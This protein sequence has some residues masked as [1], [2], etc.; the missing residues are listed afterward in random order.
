MKKILFYSALLLQCRVGIS[1]IPSLYPLSLLKYQDQSLFENP[2]ASV[3]S[4]ASEITLL[5]SNYTGLG[6]NVGLNYLNAT[7]S[8]KNKNTSN[9]HMPGIVVH[10]E[11]DTEILTRNRFY[12]KYAWSTSISSSTKISAGAHLGFFNYA[13]KSSNS[14][15]GVSAFAPDATI[16]IWI[17]NPKANI[18]FSIP[19]ITNAQVKPINSSFI[20]Q[21][22]YILFADYTILST[23]KNELKT[24]LKY[25]T[26]GSNY[27]MIQGFLNLSLS[28]L[29][30]SEFSYSLN[31]GY[32]F[33]AGFT[34]FEILKNQT[35]LFFSYFHSAQNIKA[36]SLDRIEICLRYRIKKKIQEVQEP[37]E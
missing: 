25:L 18:G 35:D 29:F 17:S 4:T 6:G 27:S 19:Q 20:L 5:H 33:S 24:G 3:R 23:P 8:I 28:K 2:A 15:S 22:H 7:A 31:R 36:L 10:S 1:Q 13:V 14:S 26:N 32:T 11:F 9:M 30:A 37:D 12:L 21:R 16:G 34:N